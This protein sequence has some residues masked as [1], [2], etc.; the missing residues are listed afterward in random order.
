MA[1]FLFI[2]LLF[3]FCNCKGT[4]HGNKNSKDTAILARAAD[5]AS[6]TI[7]TTPC[8]EVKGKMKAPAKADMDEFAGVLKSEKLTAA[9]NTNQIPKK[10]M[11]LLECI[12]PASSS[13]ANPGKPWNAGCT[14]LPDQ[15]DHQLISIAQN[16]HWFLM[17]YRSGGFATSAD[18]IVIHFDGDSLIDYRV[19]PG[20]FSSLD[21]RKSLMKYLLSSP[22]RTAMQ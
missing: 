4:G 15:P 19:L 16:D 20:Y 11:H 3:A 1:R 13:I 6:D 17:N 7:F 10:V 12:S 18:L 14:R 9:R 5:M 2:L 21:D 8:D 22:A